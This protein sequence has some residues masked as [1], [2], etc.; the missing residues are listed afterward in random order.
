MLSLE[1][2]MAQGPNRPSDDVKQGMQEA[3]WVA[4]GGLFAIGNNLHF[5]FFCLIFTGKTKL[6]KQP[7]SE[8]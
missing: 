8:L 4:L 1:S 7:F 3:K 2:H 6:A 5:F